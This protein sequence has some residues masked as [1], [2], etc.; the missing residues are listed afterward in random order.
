MDITH[1]EE[2]FE[3]TPKGEVG[4]TSR[5]RRIHDS[6]GPTQNEKVGLAPVVAD[7]DGC[8]GDGSLFGHIAVGAGEGGCE[9]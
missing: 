8:R 9:G 7:G 6:D 4:G 3:P 5:R 2:I 1:L